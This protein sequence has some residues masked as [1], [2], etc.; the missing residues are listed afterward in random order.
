M[1]TPEPFKSKIHNMLCK[2]PNFLFEE[3]LSFINASIT[4][5]SNTVYWGF[6]KFK[7]LTFSCLFL[8]NVN[9][10]LEFGD[11]LIWIKMH[12]F[13]KLFSFNLVHVHEIQASVFK[14]F[15]TLYCSEIL[16]A[17]RSGF[18]PT[19]YWR[20]NGI[21]RLSAPPV[22]KRQMTATGWK[23]TLNPGSVHSVLRDFIL[24][25]GV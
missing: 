11:N 1:V 10:H 5:T 13:S 19:W 15:F 12:I 8:T 24:C 14:A 25:I 16:N 21:Q 3:N 7:Q 2:L 6:L 17:L 20:V 4:V 18:S 22:L 23:D 9:W